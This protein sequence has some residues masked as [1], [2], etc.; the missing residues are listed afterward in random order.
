MAAS[1]GPSP[2]FERRPLGGTPL[3]MLGPG[4]L[5]RQPQT[6]EQARH[7]PG[8]VADAVGLLGTGAD[9]D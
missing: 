3:G 1:F 4:L 9:V 2:F 5:A 7:A 8:A 6:L